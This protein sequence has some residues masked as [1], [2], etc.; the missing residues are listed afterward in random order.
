MKDIYR[1]QIDGLFDGGVD[2]ILIETVFDSPNAKAA[3]VAADE[4]AEARGEA[5]CR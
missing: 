3:L 4:A 2:F 5:N 1:E